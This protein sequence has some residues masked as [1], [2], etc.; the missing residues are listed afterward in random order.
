V[1]P[2]G[3]SGGTLTLDGQPFR[4]LGANV[5]YLQ[6]MFAYDELGMG[7]AA[8]QARTALDA[9]VCLSMNVVRLWAF[10]DSTDSSSIRRAPGVYS[11]S[12]LRGLDRAVAE[13]KGRGLRVILTLVNGGVDYGGLGAYAAWN[14]PATMPMAE[15]FYR[16]PAIRQYWKDYASMLVGRINTV[17]GIAY[18]D[19]PAILAWEVGN[20]LRCESCA[21]TSLWRDTMRELIDYLRATGVTQL[22]ADGSDGFDEGTPEYLGL[23]NNYPLSGVQG[24]SFSQLLTLEGLDMVS[25]HAYPDALGLD[26]GPDLDIWIS[27]HQ[28]KARR[29]GKVAYL[30]EFGHNPPASVDQDRTR[31]RQFGRWLE[32]FY[33]PGT[34]S[35]ALLWQLEPPERRPINDDGYGV[36]FQLDP[37]SAGQLYAWAS[38]LLTG[39]TLGGQP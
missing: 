5:Y 10:N 33:G 17:T 19:E 29:A 14:D 27:A 11:A 32:R 22:I 12:G 34:G 23:S 1:G 28:D 3:R 9:M 20:E 25:Y 15:R 2:V 36:V 8:S 6:Q 37:L 35:L 38:K 18:R 4:A 31:A 16:E 7:W 30:G 26:P 39:K 21:G 24:T 13:A